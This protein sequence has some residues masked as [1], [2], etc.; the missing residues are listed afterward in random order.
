MTSCCRAASDWFGLLLTLIAMAV[1]V[2]ACANS[3]I[4]H[5]WRFESDGFLVDSVGGV[6]LRSGDYQLVNLP[7]E[8]DQAGASF[9]NGFDGAGENRSGM[10]MHPTMGATATNTTPV[11]GSFTVEMYVH[12]DSL[13]TTTFTHFLGGQGTPPATPQSWSWGPQVRMDESRGTRAREFVLLV[14][15]GS[16]YI[17]PPSGIF[18]APNIDYYLGAS[19][20]LEGKELT[21]YVQDLT[22]GSILSSVTVPHS[23]DRVKPDTN[24]VVGGSNRSCCVP[25]GVI[26]EFRVANRVLN[27]D[28]LLVSLASSVSLPGDFDGDGSVSQADYSVWASTYGTTPGVTADANSDGVIDAADYTVWRDNLTAPA[29]NLPEPTAM[30]LVLVGF[31]AIRGPVTAGR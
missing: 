18:L 22:N 19:F 20:D 28:E 13:P 15:D 8:G 21:Y 11:D 2:P 16:Q 17:Y 4:L 10:Q 23:L 3:D 5:W 14:G 24:I 27:A 29:A 26:D 12:F 30:G 25:I 31:A 7:R 6:V 1:C 9:P